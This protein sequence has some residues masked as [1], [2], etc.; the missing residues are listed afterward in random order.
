MPESDVKILCVVSF[1]WILSRFFWA[2]I[3][4]FVR[5]TK[6][7][8]ENRYSKER[9]KMNVSEM[10]SPLAP[11]ADARVHVTRSFSH[12]FFVFFAFFSEKTEISF[13]PV[14]L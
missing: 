13:R 2:L 3:D 9:I 11:D 7:Q 10:V 12:F 14:Q 6:T 4:K 8:I 1:L 5:V